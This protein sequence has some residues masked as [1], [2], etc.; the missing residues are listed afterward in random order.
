[1]KKFLL[2]LFFAVFTPFLVS[3]EPVE[4]EEARAWANQKGAEILNI[5]SS[6]DEDKYEQLDVILLNDVDIKY[7]AKFVVGKYWKK[8]T[9]EQKSRYLASFEEYLMK[10]YKTFNLD[11][12][13]S[14]INFEIYDIKVSTK[15]TDIIMSIKIKG[16]TTESDGAKDEVFVTFRIHKTDNRIKLTDLKIAESSLSMAYRNRVYE[17][18]QQDEEEIDWFLDDFETWIPSEQDDTLNEEQ[19]AEF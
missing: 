12:K 19:S 16:V 18:I 7:I 1:M 11:F 4:R 9:D 14:D 2:C 15:F 6:K 8:M 13:A 17:L 3:A 10:I 5:I